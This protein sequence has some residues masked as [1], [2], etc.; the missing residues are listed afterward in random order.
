MFCSKLYTF[1]LA[2]TKWVIHNSFRHNK[3]EF[4]EKIYITDKVVQEAIVHIFMHIG[5]K[6]QTVDLFNKG[7]FKL[8][9]LEFRIHSS[10][11][12]KRYHYFF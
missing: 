10:Y 3:K 12:Y 7:A 4:F 9:T 2:F 6:K 8:D 5:K 11:R 1:A